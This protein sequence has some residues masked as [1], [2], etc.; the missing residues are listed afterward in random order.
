M[1][2]RPFPAKTPSCKV[3]T[4]SKTPSEMKPSLSAWWRPP[5][6]NNGNWDKPT[7]NGLSTIGD[8]FFWGGWGVGFLESLS[9][10]QV[11]SKTP[12]ALK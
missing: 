1:L 3:F 4:R 6:P 9:Q 5:G 2:N 12:K 11:A 8:L 10:N 7:P